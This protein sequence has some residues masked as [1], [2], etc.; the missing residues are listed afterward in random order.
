LAE[1]RTRRQQMVER[2]IEHWSS[3]E[4]DQLAAL[5]QRFLNDLDR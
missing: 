1:V 5:L 3:N 2:A 4:V